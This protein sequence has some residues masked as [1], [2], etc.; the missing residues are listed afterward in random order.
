MVSSWHIAR[1][2]MESVYSWDSKRVRKMEIV[3]GGNRVE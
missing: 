2:S 1:K 3:Y